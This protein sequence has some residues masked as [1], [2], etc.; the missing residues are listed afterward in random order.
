MAC[1]RNKSDLSF[2]RQLS[3]YGTGKHNSSLCYY[4]LLLLW[5]T[6]YGS[7]GIKNCY[8]TAAACK[9]AAAAFSVK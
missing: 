5:F 2:K 9:R 6:M 3:F 7:E 4:L 8:E 1:Q